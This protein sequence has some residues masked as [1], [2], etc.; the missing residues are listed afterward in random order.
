MIDVKAKP[1]KQKHL[2]LPQSDHY[3]LTLKRKG[4]PKRNT[5]SFKVYSLV[6]YLFDIQ[7][8]T[9]ALKAFIALSKN[10]GETINLK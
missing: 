10:S 5:F 1:K 3:D 7:F 8:F 2:K 4:I 9:S 6:F